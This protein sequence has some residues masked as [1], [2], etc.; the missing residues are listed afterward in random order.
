MA[1]VYYYDDAHI[2][3]Y[4]CDYKNNEWYKVV[5]YLNDTS[6]KRIHEIYDSDYNLLATSGPVDLRSGGNAD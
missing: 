4:L 1:K 5:V 3:H 2:W 6:N